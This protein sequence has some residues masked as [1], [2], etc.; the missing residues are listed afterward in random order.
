MDQSFPR[1]DYSGEQPRTELQKR[2]D[3]GESQRTILTELYGRWQPPLYR[4]VRK[5]VRNTADTEDLVQEVFLKMN[6]SFD[7]M[8]AREP[9]EAW[10]YTVAWHEVVNFYRKRGKT[11]L[12]AELETLER[13]LSGHDWS[14]GSLPRDVEGEAERWVDRVGL[15]AAHLRVL[16]ARGSIS[17]TQ[18]EDYWR[19]V[20]DGMTQQELAQWRGVHQS[21]IS[22]RKSGLVKEL[23]TA[24]YLCVILGVVRPPYRQAEIREH[25]DRFDMAFSLTEADRVLLRR[26][27]SAVRKGPD[28]QP[29]LTR[30]DARAA[31]QDSSAGRV[32]PLEELHDSESVYAAAIPN[33][34]PHCIE[35]PCAVHTASPA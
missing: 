2:V 17:S 22:Q 35:T 19:E 14:Y 11:P 28:G 3:G 32:V 12:P 24:L 30:E 7:S 18:L 5:W 15:V 25:L 21:R 31:I 23:R 8:I 29:V 9:V 20:V 27:G 6:A 10:I 33:P 13:D 4:F 16:V 26:A 34:A 1:S